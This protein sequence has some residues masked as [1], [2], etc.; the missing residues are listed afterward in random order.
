MVRFVKLFAISVAAVLVLSA[1][2]SAG[3]PET[4][5]NPPAVE[6]KVE[7]VQVTEEVEVLS[8]DQPESTATSA[9][10]ETPVESE[11]P[12]GEPEAAEEMADESPPP[13]LKTG[14]EATNPSTVNLASGKI[15]LVELFA[16]W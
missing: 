3:A 7:E 2:W 15:Q 11:M 5:A 1:C 10:T 12:E 9:P 6:S 16:F 13:V 4:N 8:D 14:L